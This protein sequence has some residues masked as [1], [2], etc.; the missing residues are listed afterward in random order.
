VALRDGRGA[1]HSR[2]ASGET[3]ED[4]NE[5]AGRLRYLFEERVEED[6]GLD[7]L[8]E[9]HLVGQ[10][11]VC[12]LSPGEPE[13][14][15]TLQLVQ[16]QRPAGR[17]DKVGLLLVFYRWLD[18]EKKVREKLSSF[19]VVYSMRSTTILQCYMSQVNICIHQFKVV[20][21]VF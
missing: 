12:A 11:G 4:D 3:R 18:G 8:A 1:G 5:A 15:Q 17:R 16:V 20:I 7:G 19:I 14:V 21:L 6:D 9:A 10:D 2:G 13:P